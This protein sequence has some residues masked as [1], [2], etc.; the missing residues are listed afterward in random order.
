MIYRTWVQASINPLVAV[1]DAWRTRAEVS[2]GQG[3]LPAHTM[4]YTFIRSCAIAHR[5]QEGA[6]GPYLILIHSDCGAVFDCGLATGSVGGP[7]GRI[8]SV[9]IQRGCGRDVE[10]GT[11]AGW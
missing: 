11:R 3:T 4:S 7:D 1:V 6:V 5:R 2:L 9:G 8:G 10:A